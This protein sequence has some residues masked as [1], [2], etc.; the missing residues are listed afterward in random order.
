MRVSNAMEPSDAQFGA[1]LARAGD[2][3]VHLLNLL[4]FR[5]KAAYA[6]GREPDL[7]G[8]DAY[9]RY[10]GPMTRLVESAGGR[11]RFSAL[12][13]EFL[14]GHAD[15]AWDMIAIM[16]YPSASTLPEIA[17][18]PAFREIEIHRKAGL[19]G[20]LLIPCFQSETFVA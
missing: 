13:S 8:A 20:Q 15:E 2:G 11:L 16:T 10:G 1:F 3:P 4:K 9:M 6:D 12:P 17:E 18:T 19:A 14:I 5:D 7:S